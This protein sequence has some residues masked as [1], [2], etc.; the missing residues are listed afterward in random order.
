[1][2]TPERHL[3]VITDMRLLA[4]TSAVSDLY[5][6]LCKLNELRE[7]V[8]KAELAPKSRRIHRR[9]TTLH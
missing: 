5:D 8:R 6:Q 7:R 4:M 3:M 9:K 2:D 1:M